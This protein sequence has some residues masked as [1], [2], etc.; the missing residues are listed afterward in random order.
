MFRFNGQ[1]RR[2][3]KGYY[4]H[5]IT[6]MAIDW[7]KQRDNDRPFL[8]F[9]GHKAPHSFYYPEPRY[10]HAFDDVDI[11]YPLTAFHL[12]D[13]PQVVSVASRHLARYL[14]SHL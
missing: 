5:V 3:V 10:E 6:E 11:R 9:M 8:L 2:E 14:R 12:E 4:T 13:N 7:L 1:E